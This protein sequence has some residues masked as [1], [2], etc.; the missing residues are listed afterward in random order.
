MRTLA[1]DETAF[2]RTF[3][4]PMRDVTADA[5][6]V[7]D[8]WPYVQAIP[9]S[10]LSSVG[11]RNGEVDYVYRSGDD[12]FDHVLI[13]TTV[14]NVYLTVVVSRRSRAV[15]GHHVLDLNQKYGL[16]PPAEALPSMD[17]LE[18][19]KAHKVKPDSPSRNST[20]GIAL[21]TLARNPINGLR[22]RPE[23]GT[24]GWYI[25][26]GPGL[27]DDP[28][29][30]QPLHWSHLSKHCPSVLPYLALPPGWR[31]LLG[32]EGHVD[33]WYDETLLRPR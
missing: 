4:S 7:V 29:L 33:V 10:D 8:I 3:V 19:C 30:F 1:L 26:G 25:W 24:C 6:P 16:P 14:P 13:P 32:T 18:V 11:Y 23:G 15:H 22:S 17:Q 28:R 2:Q 9:T 20:L 12:R 5:D 21:A 31:F 27:C